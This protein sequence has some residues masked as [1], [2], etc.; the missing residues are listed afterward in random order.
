MTKPHQMINCLFGY[1][2]YFGHQSFCRLRVYWVSKDRPW[3]VVVT[4][5]QDNPGTSVTNRA[6]VIRDLASSELAIP[7]DSMV[8]IEHYHYP[9]AKPEDRNRFSTVTFDVDDLG[10]SRC[11]RWQHLEASTLE[12]WIGEP[13]QD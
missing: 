11:P 1:P 10:R 4:E 13:I 9:N 6:E 8:W 3:Y 7:R 2:G 12:R 5:L